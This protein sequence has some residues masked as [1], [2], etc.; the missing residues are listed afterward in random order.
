[1]FLWRKVLMLEQQIHAVHFQCRVHSTRVSGVPWC[2]VWY[3]RILVL[4][5]ETGTVEFTP[6]GLLQC[7]SHLWVHFVF[8]RLWIVDIFAYWLTEGIVSSESGVWSFHLSHA[9]KL[10]AENVKR[11]AAF[12]EETK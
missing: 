9:L 6:T 7:R 1:M 10:S 5:P 12:E 4:S 8:I 2:T 3:A 11:V